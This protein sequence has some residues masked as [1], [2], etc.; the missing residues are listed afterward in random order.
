[1]PALR[2]VGEKDTRR[3]KELGRSTNISSSSP[4]MRHMLGVSNLQQSREFVREVAVRRMFVSPDKEYKVSR[5][6][7][8]F[9]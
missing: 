6:G 2:H 4:C 9:S 3:R 7:V 5:G 1:M 8:V